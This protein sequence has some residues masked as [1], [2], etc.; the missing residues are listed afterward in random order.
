MGRIAFILEWTDVRRPSKRDLL[1]VVVGFLTYIVAVM[2]ISAIVSVFQTESATHGTL[3][4][5]D[6]F[7]RATLLQVFVVIW[8]L[9]ALE[10]YTFRNLLQK[11]LYRWMDYRAAIGL[12]SVIF[13]GLHVPAYG[14]LGT[15]LDS[16]AMSLG[17]V[18]VGSVILGYAYWRTAN[19]VVPTAIHGLINT[20]ALTVA[21]VV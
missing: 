9:V 15:P 17:V 12:T 21:V 11:L 7:D 18:F 20:M 16:L 10:E 14:G 2:A 6:S 19:V 5:A 8:L 4:R 1:V 13:A 3:A